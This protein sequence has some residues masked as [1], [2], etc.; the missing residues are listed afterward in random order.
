M[1]RRAKQTLADVVSHPERVETLANGLKSDDPILGWRTVRLTSTITKVGYTLTVPADG[2]A[3]TLKAFGTGQDGKPIPEHEP[4][5]LPA[6]Q[7]FV[8]DMVAIGWAAE[9]AEA[10]PLA[11]EPT[12]LQAPLAD[13]AGAYV[14]APGNLRTAAAALR[15][16]TGGNA[17]FTVRS[18]KT[19]TRYTYRVNRA[20]CSR[21]Q[22]L[23][24]KCWAWP[25]Y[26]VALLSGPD[27]T[28]DYTYLGMLR[29]N[30]FRL[31]RASKMQ[32][33]SGPVKAFRWVYERL[34]RREMPTQT[35]IWHEGR[36]GVCG[37]PLTVPESIES[38]IGPVCA[39]KGGL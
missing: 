32:D 24:C 28:A 1:T 6:P 39:G 18:Q 17:Y 23:D 27:N 9:A 10:L 20:A 19:G 34:V 4:V 30:Q 33:S 8:D 7:Q 26:F 37:R 16:I 15:F 5:P 35:E 12:P 13:A 22:K 31:T 14:A 38:G 2:S 21:C 3:G 11:A 25:T 36:C 29:E